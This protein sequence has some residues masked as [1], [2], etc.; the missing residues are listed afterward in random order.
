MYYIHIV[1]VVWW[2]MEC[3]GERCGPG[4]K[5]VTSPGACC[6]HCAIDHNVC[7]HEG[8]MR[9]VGHVSFVSSS[10]H[11]F[12]LLILIQYTLFHILVHP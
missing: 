8:V 6:P 9:Q 11:P 12:L 4:E 7:I 10:C 3:G 2:Q 5:L 1:V